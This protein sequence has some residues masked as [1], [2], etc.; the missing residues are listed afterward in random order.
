[1]ATTKGVEVTGIYNKMPLFRACP[2]CGSQ[3][4][5]RKLACPCGHSV[6]R[7]SKL[8]TTRNAPGAR[9]SPDFSPR[10]RDKIWEWPG[11]HMDEA[12]GRSL[13]VLVVMMLDHTLWLTMHSG[14]Q[15]EAGATSG[16]IA[17]LAEAVGYEAF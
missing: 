7:G 11:D 16:V 14:R 9:P 4:H 10:L 3:I 15:E 5:V 8:L 12:R 1:M 13:Y 17:S 2:N 6:F